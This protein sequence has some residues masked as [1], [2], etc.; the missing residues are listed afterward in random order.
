[1]CIYVCVCGE[2]EI[3]RWSDWEMEKEYVEDKAVDLQMFQQAGAPLSR[4]ISVIQLCRV[5]ARM[6]LPIG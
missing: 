6:W 1:M 5:P 3:V 4:C 2:K